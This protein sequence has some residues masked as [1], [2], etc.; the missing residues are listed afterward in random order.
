MYIDTA[1]SLAHAETRMYL[2]A[3]YTWSLARARE[4]SEIKQIRGL[5][6]IVRACAYIRV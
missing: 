1:R 4:S 3:A 6:K 5:S 2:P